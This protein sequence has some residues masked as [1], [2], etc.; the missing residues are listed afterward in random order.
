MTIS[1]KMPERWLE[2][3]ETQ[4]T[5][6]VE[7]ERLTSQQQGDEML[8]MGLRLNEGIDVQRYERMAGRTFDPRRLAVLQEEGMIEPVGNSRLRATPKGM[9]LL[10][11]VLV[12]LLR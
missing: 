11:A 12:E 7:E 6:V 8:M 4:G 1:E 9:I 3:V 5:G 10:D 2:R